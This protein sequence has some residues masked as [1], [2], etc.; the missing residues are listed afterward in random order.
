MESRA[1]VFT[2]QPLDVEVYSAGEWLPGLLL[3]WR[4]DASGICQV[5]VQLT[6]GSSEKSTW[7]DLEC[8]RL[9][10]RHLAPGREPVEDLAATRS[11]RLTGVS[12]GGPVRHGRPAAPAAPR[13]TLDAQELAV[14]RSLPVIGDDAASRAVH[15]A[16]RRRADSRVVGETARF[17]SVG[18]SV[19]RHRAPASPSVAGR[20]RA[21]DA[22]AW[23]VVI[24]AAV[25]ETDGGG[26]S[27][28]ARAAQAW[29]RSSGDS[30]ATGA[31][32]DEMS[33][34]PSP[35]PELLTRPMRLGGSI[36]RH[37]GARWDDTLTGV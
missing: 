27:P 8:L 2:S 3:G 31:A 36:P 12:A 34:T 15:P 13:S 11:L 7:T 37:R 16:G 14:P 4:H 32:G 33:D 26:R 1:A 19:G 9:P 35:A 20:H 21:A 23:P 6:G 17:P 24:E 30:G 5:C 25:I 28:G 29:S 22:G 10:E 18:A